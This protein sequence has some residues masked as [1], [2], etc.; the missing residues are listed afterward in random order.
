M[1][2]MCVCACACVRACVFACVS[3]CMSHIISPKIYF[4]EFLPSTDIC[5]VVYIS[6]IF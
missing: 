3:M 2:Y 1:S 5:S 4:G 6:D